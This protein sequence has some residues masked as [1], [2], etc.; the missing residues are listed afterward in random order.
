MKLISGVMASILIFSVYACGGTGRTDAKDQPQENLETLQPLTGD[1]IRYLAFQVFEGSPNPEIPFDKA[2]VYTPR[3]AVG[4]MVHDIATTIGATG[5]AKT[6]LAFILGP[7]A[8]DHTDAQVRQIIDDGFEIALAE[9]IAVGFH[10]DDAMFWSK[11]PDLIENPDN[12]EWTDFAGTP[13][14]G[15]KLD[16]AHVP[17][18]MVF[19]APEIQAEVTRRARDVIGSHIASHVEIL[20]ARGKEDL[21]AGIIAGWE[22]HMGQ[23]IGTDDRVGFHAL[24]NRGFGPGKPPPNVTAEIASIVNE[25]I[26]LWTDG[27]AAGGVGGDRIYTHVAFL[28][29]ARFEEMRTPPGLAYETVLDVA[30]SSQRP[31]T[32]FTS[33]GRPGFSTY[34]VTGVFEQIQSELGL[35]NKPWWASVE[36][37]NIIPG[38]PPRSSWMTMENYLAKSFNNG[39]ALV[40]LF[41]WGIGGDIMPNNPFKMATQG[42]TA[43]AAYR[44]FLEQ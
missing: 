11:R 37:T 2:L 26:N 19:N 43:L 9:N 16:W 23:D 24:A 7:I 8:F 18:R 29:R 6:R 31:A 14:V 5:G 32:A 35:H 13:A 15:L 10:I 21:F 38:D 3:A 33:T 20:R 4:K 1:E 28:P 34:P 42:E 17:P 40:T 41:G 27:L 44:K 12:I 30:P 25:F 22:S 39:A 36:G